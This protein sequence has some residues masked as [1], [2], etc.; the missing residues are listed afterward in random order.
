MAI[1]K[2]RAAGGT[3]AANTDRGALRQAWSDERAAARAARVGG[4]AATEW[5]H[6]ERAHI[7]SQPMAGPHVVTHVDMLRFGIRHRDGREI[8]GQLFRG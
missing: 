4:D 3:K 6:L 2:R 7:L 8:V 5:Q 1:E